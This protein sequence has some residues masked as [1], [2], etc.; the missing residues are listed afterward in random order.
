MTITT[1]EEFVELRTADDPR[2][3]YDDAPIEV[4]H[5]VIERYPDMHHWVAYNKTVPIEI[6]EVLAGSTDARV[7]LMVAM[8]RKATPTILERLA[9][10]EDDSVR[11]AV[12]RHRATPRAVLEALLDDEWDEVR[13]LARERLT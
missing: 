6:L 2:A 1:A 12:A 5:D 3:S 4:W 10:D 7:R 11:A 8:K 9:T 13:D